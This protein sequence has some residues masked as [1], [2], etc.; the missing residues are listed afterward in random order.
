MELQPGIHVVK[1]NFFVNGEPQYALG[2]DLANLDR[3]SDCKRDRGDFDLCLVYFSKPTWDHTKVSL[4]S[5]SSTN[6][7]ENP[8]HELIRN[9]LTEANNNREERDNYI[10]GLGESMNKKKEGLSR[11]NTEINNLYDQYLSPLQSQFLSRAKQKCR[12][13]HARTT[14][15]MWIFQNISIDL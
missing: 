3:D 15:L 9:L 2:F 6:I 4:T 10:K 13:M 11:L 8:S 7:V 5:T 12:M 1:T 14:A